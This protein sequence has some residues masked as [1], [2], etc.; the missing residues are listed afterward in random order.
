MMCFFLIYLFIYVFI[1]VERPKQLTYKIGNAHINSMNLGR[2]A[3]TPTVYHIVRL[4]A[5]CAHIQ[6]SLCQD[7][8]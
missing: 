4:L 6:T 7:L 1:Y 8:G 2:G 5:V 3:A